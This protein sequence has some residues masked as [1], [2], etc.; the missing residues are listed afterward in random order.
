MSWRGVLPAFQ[1][2]VRLGPE[3]MRHRDDLGPLAA[4][5]DVV[6]PESLR[7]ELVDVAT[8]MVTRNAC[9]DSA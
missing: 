9:Q 6:E 1:F 2:R 4:Q 3:A 8:E 7:V 5:V